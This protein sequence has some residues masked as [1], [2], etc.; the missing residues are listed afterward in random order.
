MNNTTQSNNNGHLHNGLIYAVLPMQELIQAGRQLD[1][2]EAIDNY[3]R[4]LAKAIRTD[5]YNPATN[6][7]DALRESDFLKNVGELP[8]AE[9]AAGHAAIVVRDAERQ[10]ATNQSSL[11][12]PKL[13]LKVVVAAV[14]ALAISIS[15]TL[16]DQFFSKMD[17]K[18]LGWFFSLAGGVLIGLFIAW[19]IVGVQ[20]PSGKRSAVNLVGLLAACGIGLFCFLLRLSSGEILSAIALTVLEIST[21]IILECLAG[22]LRGRHAQFTAACEQQ[23]KS[24]AE[25][26]THKAEAG[27]RNVA[28]Q[29]I[30]DRIEAHKAYLGVRHFCSQKPQEIEQASLDI[31]RRAFHE[32]V[33]EEER[34]RKGLPKELR[35]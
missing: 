20:D 16:F 18:A 9:K 12:E 29:E 27:R 6:P 21:V 33:A 4:S 7:D 31:A 34:I 10:H 8:E 19:S 2:V 1:N 35:V 17:D 26:Q 30:K 25:V 24:A 23:M 28:V 15:P 22:S 5:P 13:P 32:R 14:G 11:I 3:A